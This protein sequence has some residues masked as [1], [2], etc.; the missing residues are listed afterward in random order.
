MPK[1]KCGAALMADSRAFQVRAANTGNAIAEGSEMRCWNNQ[2]R[3]VCRM[4][5]SSSFH[6]SSQLEQLRKI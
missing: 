4:K 2:R 3:G 1:T 6:I 5:M